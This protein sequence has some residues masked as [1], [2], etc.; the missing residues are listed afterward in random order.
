MVLQR[1]DERRQRTMHAACAERVLG[2]RHHRGRHF[3][4]GPGS[5]RLFASQKYKDA[6][7]ANTDTRSTSSYMGQTNICTQAS[8]ESDQERQS[9]TPPSPI[10]PSRHHVL[11]WNTGGTTICF[12]CP[13]CTICSKAAWLL[14]HAKFLGLFGS[15]S[16]QLLLP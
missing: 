9:R 10:R 13:M 8:P 4:L 12:L 11:V 16:H 7:T 5:T 3:G 15:V 1:Q 2:T 14:P 6:G